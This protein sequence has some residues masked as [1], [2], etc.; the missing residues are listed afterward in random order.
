MGKSHSATLSFAEKHAIFLK[1]HSLG[2]QIGRKNIREVQSRAQTKF[3]T[4]QVTILQY[5]YESFDG[6][7]SF[8]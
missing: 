5:V 7:K 4:L 1:F 6:R 8:H 3:T 2:I